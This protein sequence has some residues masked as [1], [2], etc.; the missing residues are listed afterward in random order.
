MCRGAIVASI[1]FFKAIK[2]TLSA[3]ESLIMSSALLLLLVN[4]LLLRWLS[5][6]KCKSLFLLQQWP[7][8]YRLLLIHT[9][10]SYQCY[11]FSILRVSQVITI[12]IITALSTCS[13]P[14]PLL[15]YL[16]IHI[17]F[18]EFA[19]AHN[20]RISHAIKS[21]VHCRIQCSN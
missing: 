2:S 14:L 7:F 1:P 17:T 11:Y 9:V 18:G 20:I 3:M 16:R 15:L 19:Q 12:T 10:Q 4:S 6:I 5:R 21:K 8:H 13:L